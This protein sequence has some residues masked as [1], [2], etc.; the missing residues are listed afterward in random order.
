LNVFII[1]IVPF[2]IEA[3]AKTEI[4]TGTTSTAL[5]DNHTIEVIHL[6]IFVLTLYTIFRNIVD[7]SAHIVMK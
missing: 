4:M 1:A 6:V 3:F 2:S 5:V 7:G